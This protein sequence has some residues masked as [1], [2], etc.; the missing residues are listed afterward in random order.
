MKLKHFISFV[1]FALLSVSCNFSPTI[2]GEK[3]YQTGPQLAN[4]FVVADNYSSDDYGDLI[5]RAGILG[6]FLAS[7]DIQT[8]KQTID[9]GGEQVEEVSTLY[10]LEDLRYEYRF[11]KV[12]TDNYWKTNYRGES[13][14]VTSST[15]YVLAYK[16]K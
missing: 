1:T 4:G 5:R 10:K 15:T 14:F 16:E 8:S 3:L 13:E 11:A 7:D 12:K 9:I 2:N 6:A